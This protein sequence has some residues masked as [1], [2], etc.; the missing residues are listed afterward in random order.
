M[1]ISN[2]LYKV[3]KNN[4]NQDVDWNNPADVWK[5]W[6]KKGSKSWKKF[7]MC[8]EE[9]FLFDRYKKDDKL[10]SFFRG[11]AGEFEKFADDWIPNSERHSFFLF[12]AESLWKES[13]EEV[14]ALKT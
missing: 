7:V 11:Y 12:Y 5:N 13:H 6:I 1:E 8:C 4:E 3:I 9:E 2:R 14:L 10:K